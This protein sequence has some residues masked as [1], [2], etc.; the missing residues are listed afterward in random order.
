MTLSLP[1]VKFVH[2][3]ALFRNF[4]ERTDANPS[5]LPFDVKLETKY[6]IKNLFSGKVEV[7]DSMLGDFSKD[8]S[9]MIEGLAN[10]AFDSMFGQEPDLLPADDTKNIANPENYYPIHKDFKFGGR[11]FTNPTEDIEQLAKSIWSFNI[12]L[13]TMKE[14]YNNQ[15]WTFEPVSVVNNWLFSTRNVTADTLWPAAP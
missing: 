10:F 2:P 12:G 14:V 8:L 3:Q 11:V 15:N 4:S 5:K 6:M 7:T 9:A 1:T 13:A